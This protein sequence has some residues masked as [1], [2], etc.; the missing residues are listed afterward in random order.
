MSIFLQ[1]LRF[2]VRT[3]L[4]APL[5][6][7]LAI[8]CLALGIGA[9]ATMF[10]VFDGILIKPFPFRDPDRIVV[11]T[12]TNRRNGIDDGEMSYANFRDVR[13]ASRTLTDVAA[14]TGRSLT[15]MYDTEAVRHAGI[16][17]SW[18]LF[19]LLGVEPQLGRAF[20]R[21]DD[22]P[23]ALGTVILS[24]AVWRARFHADPA[25]IGRSI[26]VNDAPHTIV[27]VMPPRF[28]FPQNG[29][30]WIPIAPVHNA[31]PRASRAMRVYGRL[32]PGVSRDAAEQEIVALGSRLAGQY[33]DNAGWS[34]R[35]MTLG[36]D[37]LPDEPRLV[38]IAAMGAVSL[39]LL[40]ACAN[41]A[42]L[43][44]ARATAR[45]REIAIRTAVG[46]GRGRILR[47]LIT[48]S[49]VLGAAGAPLGL[50]LT[51]VGI[52]LM[53]A[54]IP[55]PDLLPYYVTWTIDARVV[56]YVIA[57]A[58]GSGVLFGLAPALQTAHAN[59]VEA[60]KDG[61]RGSSVG[62][63]RGRFRSAL[64]VSEI[65][66]SL[67]LLVGASLFVRSFFNLQ[68]ASAGFQTTP[69]LALRFYMPGDRYEP[70][71]AIASRV[72]DV[73]RRVESVPGVAGAAASNY[74][75]LTGGG[76]G[77][78][79]IVDGRPAT[80]GEE[81]RIAFAGVTP[82]FFRT[83]GIRLRNGRDFTDAE[84]HSRS[85]VA[86]V[87]ATMAARFWPGKD[88]VGQ[89]FRL[90]DEA[91]GDWFTVIGI[92]PDIARGFVGSRPQPFAFLP[93][94]FSET[95]NTGI[96][97][98]VERGTP[99]S[100]LAAVRD[101]IRAADASMPIFQVQT[102]EEARARGYW[103]YRLFSW[104]FSIFGA[105]ALAL[106]AVGV[107]G[108]LAYSVSQRTHEIGVRMALG[109]RAADVRRMITAQGFRLA[110]VGIVVGA[111]GAA[112]LTQGLR[113]LLF[114]VSATDPVS[115]AGVAL[116]LA[117]VAIA[118]SWLPARR[119]TRVDPIIALRAE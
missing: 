32:A 57:V 91:N 51:F 19:D 25:I 49:I 70:A 83:L 81:P 78:A 21:D 7:G 113:S 69:L 5:V 46:A 94:P 95:R 26:I 100:V 12:E 73:M 35:T 72:E 30:A 42:N 86:V 52:R 29:E 8:L 82:H 99:T 34:M 38:T 92:A 85:R 56:A 58:V 68:T 80:P 33:V 98:R 101:Q 109:A 77:G 24:D 50:A 104:M 2:A 3:L 116:F 117:G 59:L 65:A 67:V 17:V 28:A 14:F 60:L 23:G 15:F 37:L 61:A 54:G 41:V 75:P 110:A 9:N 112:G 71:G 119:A 4:R 40:I 96:V 27:G 16:V 111:I 74:V 48:E 47:Q 118:A 90:V 43:L 39:V 10:S 64:V 84:G 6:S 22:Q 45:H 103:Q 62:G 87:N 89:R 115:Y 106:A 55:S 108:V 13:D 36:E 88:A 105:I 1:D 20:R 63:R 93:H 114:N 11:V 18:N 66:L 53:D 79:I 44:L 31:D 102:M 107:Y 76:D 97:L